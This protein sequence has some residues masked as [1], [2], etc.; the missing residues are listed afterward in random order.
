MAKLNFQMA[1][2]TYASAV[3]QMVSHYWPFTAFTAGFC[4][5]AEF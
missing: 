2:F 5:Q 4:V 1:Y 3:W